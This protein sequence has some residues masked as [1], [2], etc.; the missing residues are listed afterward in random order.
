[1]SIQRTARMG[2]LLA[3][4]VVLYRYSVHLPLFPTFLS[5]DA[6]EVPVVIG[7][8][9]YGPVAGLLLELLKNLMQGVIKGGAN[10]VGLAANFA[11]GGLLIVGFTPI[12]RLAGRSRWR[13]CAVGVG[14]LVMGLG[15][16]PLNYYFFL[17]AHGIKGPALGQMAVALLTPFNVVKGAVSVSLGVALYERL[18][19][20][21]GEPAAQAARK[22]V[23][24]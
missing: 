1:M 16:I 12:Y 18:R 20:A 15:L 7:A 10:P 14:A 21:L 17:P 6:S 2:V 5:Y 11:A 8:L 24:P 3:T 13:W 19:V 9:V 4:S 22:T 23:N